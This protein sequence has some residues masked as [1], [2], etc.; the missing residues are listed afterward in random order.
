VAGLGQAGV[1]NRVPPDDARSMGS[2]RIVKPSHTHLQDALRG[3]KGGHRTK[4]TMHA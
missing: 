4:T 3:S 2:E 1:I